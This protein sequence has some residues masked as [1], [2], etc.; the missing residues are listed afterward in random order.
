MINTILRAILNKN[1]DY[2]LLTDIELIIEL[3][4]DISFFK[5]LKK[6]SGIEPYKQLSE[7]LTY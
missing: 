7:R 4:K 1:P 3:T 6:E 2:R 5:R